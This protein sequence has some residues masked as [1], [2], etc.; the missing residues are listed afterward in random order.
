MANGR[1]A[2]AKASCEN[3]F[4]HQNLLCAIEGRALCD[5]PARAT[6]K[7]CDRPSQLRFVFRQERRLQ[8][9]WAFPSPSEQ[10]ALHTSVRASAG[11][12]HAAGR[13]VYVYAMYW[14]LIGGFIAFVLLAIFMGWVMD[15]DATATPTATVTEPRLVESRARESPGVTA[16]AVRPAVARSA[17][18][19]GQ[20]STRRPAVSV[21]PWT[22]IEQNTVSAARLKIVDAGGSCSKHQQRE[23]HRCHALGPEPGHERPRGR[24]GWGPASAA[25]TATGRATSSVDGDHR[26]R[27]PSPSRIAR[28]ASAAIRT[29]RRSRA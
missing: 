23:R 15:T 1:A 5:L 21:A 6:R 14:P 19:S 2:A 4:F 27:A 28:R 10:V 22:R 7:A 16:P 13:S 3:C 11:A 20:R 24:V 25:N 17:S 29:R 26:D 9:A 8:V 18:R 12:P